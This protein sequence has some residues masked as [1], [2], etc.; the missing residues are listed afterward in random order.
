MALL[1]IPEGS[2][3]IN[4]VRIQPCP[5]ADE[6]KPCKLKRGKSAIIEFDY[7]PRMFIVQV[8]RLFEIENIIIV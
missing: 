6:N 1:V 7:T 5:E 4:E 3:S 8:I 2:C